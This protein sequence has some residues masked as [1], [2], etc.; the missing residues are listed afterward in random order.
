MLIVRHNHGL[1]TLDYSWKKFKK[2]VAESSGVE[3]KT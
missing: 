1:N 2:I 3:L